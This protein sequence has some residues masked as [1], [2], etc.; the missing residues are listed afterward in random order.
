MKILIISDAWYPQVNGVVRTYEYLNEELTKMGHTIDIVGPCDFNIRMPMPG[1][2]EIKLALTPYF[3]LSQKIRSFGP[4]RI[5]IATEGP[6]GWNTRK[7]CLRNNIPFTTSYHTQFPDYVAKRVNKFLP[8]LTEKVRRGAQNMIRKFHQPSAALLV[9]TQSLEDELKEKGFTAPM[10]RL[11]RGVDTEVFKPG[12]QNLFQD[13]PRPVALYV[14]R[15][16]IEKNIEE[17]LEMDWDGSKIIVGHG[18]SMDELQKKYPDAHFVGK[19]TG[20]DL[21]DHYRSSD[22]F[23]FPSYTDTFGMVLVEAMA[24]G[25][26]LAA[27]DVVGPRDIITRP[28]LGALDTD[29]GRAAKAALQQGTAEERHT[30]VKAE[31]TWEKAAQQFI[32]SF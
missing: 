11:T 2:P 14:G 22:V 30:H 19:K 17:F 20:S 24:C 5:H 31:Y 29:L 32:E 8:F 15:V 3:R 9:A 16:A 25:L 28:E 27:H 1:Y 26:P 18:P 7:Y 10:H 13:L 23:V 12:A 21:A 6:L 4:R